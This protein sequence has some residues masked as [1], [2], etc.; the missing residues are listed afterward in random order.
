MCRVPK[1]TPTI[2]CHFY[3]PMNWL[4]TPLS[5]LRD[6]YVRLAELPPFCGGRGERLE[7]ESRA[8]HGAPTPLHVPR[9][10]DLPSRLSQIATWEACS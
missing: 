10:L 9:A 8:L 7:K 2:T 5:S 6:F 4:A 3:Q 1:G